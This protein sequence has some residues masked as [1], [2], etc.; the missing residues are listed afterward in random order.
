LQPRS[1]PSSAAPAHPTAPPARPRGP[2]AHHARALRHRLNHHQGRSLAGGEGDRLVARTQQ[3]AEPPGREGCCEGM[4][5][6]PCEYLGPWA[7]VAKCSACF[8]QCCIDAVWIDVI[9]LIALGLCNVCWF[10]I[11]S[12]GDAWNFRR[13]VP[14]DPYWYTVEEYNKYR[15]ELSVEKIQERVASG[16]DFTFPPLGRRRVQQQQQQPAPPYFDVPETWPPPRE[17]QQR[18][19]QQ[20]GAEPHLPLIPSEDLPSYFPEPQ[21]SLPAEG[22]AASF[23][24]A[25]RHAAAA[26]PRHRMFDPSAPAFIPHEDAAAYFPEPQRLIHAEGAHPTQ[27][28]PE[29]S[30]AAGRRLGEEESEDEGGGGG[31][32]SYSYDPS[33]APEPWLEPS[34]SPAPDTCNEPDLPNPID[35]LAAALA[36]AGSGAVA[37]YRVAVLFTYTCGRL[38][39][40]RPAA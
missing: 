34:P 35:I 37:A 32:Y 2:A 15:P 1:Y 23:A 19:H 20:T 6:N 3:G 14:G 40:P 28:P 8:T 29:P 13:H 4:Y 10:G 11:F 17:E 16:T 38:A 18:Q 21:G 7:L 27:R 31:S 9:W 25:D 36:S 30:A 12:V 33:P 39:L 5:S 24:F 26:P 22:A